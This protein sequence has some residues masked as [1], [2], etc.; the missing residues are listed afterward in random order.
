[1]LLT[2]EKKEML[3]CFFNKRETLLTSEKRETLLCFFNKRETLL[4]SEKKRNASHLRKKRNASHLRKKRNASFS[5]SSIKNIDLFLLIFFENLLNIFFLYKKN[6]MYSKCQNHKL[7]V[8]ICSTLL[9][10]T[11]C[12]GQGKGQITFYF[13]KIIFVKLVR[14]ELF[15]KNNL[16][17]GGPAPFLR[18]KEFKV[19]FNFS[20]HC[21]TRMVN[22]HPSKCLTSVFLRELVFPT[23]YRRS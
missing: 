19:L 20:I 15:L 17:N 9:Q 1:M 18:S 14:S 22:G 4:T 2:S 23:W 21:K 3:L 8:C 16:K 11:D 6:S 10:Q 5:A 13:G 7:K 12:R